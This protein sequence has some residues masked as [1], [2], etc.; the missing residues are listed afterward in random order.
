LHTDLIFYA[1]AI[2]AV[3]LMGLAKGGFSGV[4]QISVPLLATVVSPVQAAAI[5][6]PILLVQDAV[7]VWAF[8]RDW[9]AHILKVMVPGAAV[10]ILAGY[11]LAS[12]VS[13][14]AV[15][16][17][18]GAISIVFA[19]YQL[20]ARRAARALAVPPRSSTIM[21]FI[22]GIASGFTSQL[23]HA[24]LPPFQMWVLRKKLPPAAFIGT[25]ALFFAII[26]WVKVP[27]YAALGQFTCENLFVALTLMPVAIASTIAGVVLVRR[28][29]AEGFY[30][31]IYL[32]MI[33]VGVQL[34]WKAF[35]FG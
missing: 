5:L 34:I 10:G 22:L 33:A 8:R 26:N 11:L 15:L 14:S 7:G 9:D 28:V 25:A 13:V 23:A 30:N 24:G 21:G 20:W 27:A 6:L 35:G 12:W 19:L 29:P 31:L 3:V 18:L 32:L 16:A 2:P 4:G 17:T 1:I